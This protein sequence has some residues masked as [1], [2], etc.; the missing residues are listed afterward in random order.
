MSDFLHGA[1][2]ITIQNEGGRPITTV[3]SSTIGIVGTAPNADENVFPLN[4][5]ILV[6]SSDIEKI[7]K[8]GNDGTLP[9]SLDGIFD[10]FPATVVV[11]RVYRPP[12]NVKFSVL[13]SLTRPI[14]NVPEEEV[15][16]DNASDIDQVRY[17]NVVGL[18]KIWVGNTEY[19]K[20]VD[21]ERQDSAI[22]WI[23]NSTVETVNKTAST[24]D[25]L[26]H[27]EGNLGILKVYQGD[28]T[29]VLNTDYEMDVSGGIKWLSGAK[30]AE[31][32]NY[33]VSYEYGKRPASGSSYKVA[34]SYYDDARETK[35]VIRTNS[36]I[37]VLPDYDI[38][39][40]EKV[41]YGV[42][43]FV[44]G[45]DYELNPDEQRN[46]IHWITNET[47]ETV[48]RQVGTN[49]DILQH[50]NI[51]L[52]IAEVTQGAE[53]FVKDADWQA[54]TDGKIEW[55]S[56]NKPL[57]GEQYS[58]NYSFGDRPSTGSS[59]E[60]TYTHQIGELVAIPNVI[61]GVNVND[62]S[63]EGVHA[64]KSA[65]SVVKVVPRI[66]IAPGF[67]NFQ[68]VANELKNIAETLR[69]VV[70]I[71]GPNTTDDMAIAY[72][73]QF[74]TKRFFVV[75]PWIKFLNSNENKIDVQ[76]TSARVAG[77]IARID[78]EKGFWYSPSNKVISGCQGPARPI[79]FA[80][81][82]KNSRA[83]ILNEHEVATIISDGGE[84]RL[85]GNRTTSNNPNT[86]FLSAVRVD[87]LVEVSLQRSVLWA[88]DLNLSK[89]FFDAVTDA[90]SAYIRSLAAKGAL[91]IGNKAPCWVDPNLNT[92][93]SMMEGKAVFNF[94]Y[95][96][97]YPAEHVTF[98]RYIN[99]EYLKTIVEAAA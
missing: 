45:T 11:I 48:V 32:S 88:I 74:D 43:E 78:S 34:Y 35:Q 18:N 23:R 19:L 86:I 5:P 65:E 64:L 75:D 7:A 85:W 89:T 66:L 9:W 87:D 70:I 63:Y 30:P 24:V 44:N 52:D 21:W 1:E 20:N 59:Y 15:V 62:G 6:T 8:L 61:G 22:H 60:A 82:N 25:P 16:R 67:T 92:V 28:V 41:V 57:D 91:L 46:K 38:V 58:V 68:P 14:V 93:E 72:R 99:H 13:R 4:T 27:Q 53:T 49:V 79:E 56:A 12:S 83:N 71:D 76:P 94:D 97:L 55:I 2:V 96:R 73:E 98:R 3:S 26:V 84:Y 51:L 17:S 40:I 42:K 50:S 10:Q 37:D 80:I 77:V 29:Y 31:R 69:A 47:V 33:Y 36:D 54:T 81:G 90:V 95:D 39:S